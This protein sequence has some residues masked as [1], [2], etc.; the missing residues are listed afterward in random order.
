ML[1]IYTPSSPSYRYEHSVLGTGPPH[2][3]HL[4]HQYPVSILGY[5]RLELVADDVALSMDWQGSNL[6][7]S[8][9]LQLMRIPY[10]HI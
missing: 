7:T 9:R 5:T 4:T 3:R 10:K 8:T 2:H 1:Y 6:S